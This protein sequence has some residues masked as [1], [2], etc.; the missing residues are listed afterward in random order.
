M[1]MTYLN[2]CIMNALFLTFEMRVLDDSTT[3]TGLFR[4]PEW[5]CTSQNCLEFILSSGNCQKFSVVLNVFCWRLSKIFNC[6]SKISDN[7]Q[8]FLQVG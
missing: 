3:M 4:A 1:Y 8:G 5:R 7:V 6:Y 2:F